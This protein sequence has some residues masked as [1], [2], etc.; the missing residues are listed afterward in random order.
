MLMNA[1]II[2]IIVIMFVVIL[3]DHSI[4]LV[5]MDSY[6]NQMVEHVKV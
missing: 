1:L 6:Y 4:V 3:L 2:N 5:K